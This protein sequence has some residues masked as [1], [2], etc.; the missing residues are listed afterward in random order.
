MIKAIKTTK[1]RLLEAA[2]AIF[3]EK[4][5][6]EATVAEICEAA[7][8]NIAAVNYYFG[9]KE[10]LY[11]EVWRYAFMI[12]STAYPIDGGVS[13]DASV[14]ELLYG[15]ANALLMR[16][17]SEDERGLF[18]KLL[19]RE[20]ASPTLALEK[21]ASE[22]LLPQSAHMEKIVSKALGEKVEPRQLALCKLSII[23]QCAFY[24]FSKPLR[25]QIV[26]KS[27]FAEVEI[28]AIARH[29]A[30]FSLGGLKEIQ[31]SD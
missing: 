21:I 16:I 1:D 28:N 4:G 17:F 9:D 18:P 12:T 22:A 13:A 14:E 6:R 29:I 5:F 19:S 25:E 27:T 20:M 3:A 2:A 7:E 23:G 31:S 15:Y 10:H 8:A 11:D 24:N 30:K 26:G